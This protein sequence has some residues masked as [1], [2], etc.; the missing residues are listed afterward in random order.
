MAD[1]GP[2]GQGRSTSSSGQE[3]LGSSAQFQR[4]THSSQ[5]KREY[6]NASPF[7]AAAEVVLKN[8]TMTSGDEKKGLAMVR[9]KSGR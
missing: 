6:K 1:L 8:L 5:G 4:T 9:A 7:W 3:R 2:K